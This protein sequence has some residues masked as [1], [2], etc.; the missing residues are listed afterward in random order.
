MGEKTSVN[1][2]K[3]TRVPG[4]EKRTRAQTLERGSSAEKEGSR[5]ERRVKG[6]DRGPGRAG[7]LTQLEPPVETTPKRKIQR[8][9]GPRLGVCVQVGEGVQQDVHTNRGEKVV[10][11][12]HPRARK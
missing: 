1:R 12:F 3:R 7:K 11:C 5:C 2:V 6:R 8:W 10:L 9:Q 4:H